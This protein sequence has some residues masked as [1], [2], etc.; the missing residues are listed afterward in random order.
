MINTEK[1]KKKKSK[2]LSFFVFFNIY[3]IIELTDLHY[4]I[5]AID[6]FFSAQRHN[7]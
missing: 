7:C 6:I 1:Q 5:I 3:N 4:F 2:M